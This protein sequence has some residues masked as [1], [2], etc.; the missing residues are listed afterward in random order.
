MARWPF[1]LVGG[2]QAGAKEAPLRVLFVGSSGMR[3][4]DMP[5]QVA[6]FT[7]VSGRKLQYR[8]VLYAGFNLEDHW[9][10]GVAR[11]ALAGGGWDVVV[12]QEARRFPRT[13]STCASGR[14]AGRTWLGRR[15][16]APRY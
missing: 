6:Q 8:A 9:N 10:L 3:S 7:A 11:A 16:P 12:L 4:N 15:V 5:A 1:L 2:P 13:K 14:L